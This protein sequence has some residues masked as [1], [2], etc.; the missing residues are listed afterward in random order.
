RRR[1]LP[2]GRERRARS[3]VTADV[4]GGDPTHAQSFLHE[5][6]A[7]QLAPQRADGED[8]APRPGAAVLHLLGEQVRGETVARASQI[9]VAQV[10]EDLRRVVVLREQR[11]QSGPAL[12]VAYRLAP[13]REAALCRF[14]LRELGGLLVAGERARDGSRLPRRVPRVRQDLRPQW[15]RQLGLVDGL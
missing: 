5:E 6:R 14:G 7:G 2:D 15:R 12:G 4:P 3:S 9:E 8:R 11:A 1:V 13:Y 10:Q